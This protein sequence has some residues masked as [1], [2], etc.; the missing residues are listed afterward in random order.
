VVVDG[1]LDVAGEGATFTG[2]GLLL[3]EATGVEAFDTG[4]PLL[5]VTPD[6]IWH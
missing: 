6:G 3:G 4:S 2:G 1:E 5:Q